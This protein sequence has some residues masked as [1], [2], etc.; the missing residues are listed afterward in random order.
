MNCLDSQTR[1]QIA[2]CLIEAAR[3]GRLA[4]DGAAKN[5]VTKL[6]VDLGKC[7]RVSRQACAE[8]QGSPF[9][10]R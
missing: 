5:T 1:A 6:L 10:M 3:L 8:P 4:H 7:A 2:R 9:A